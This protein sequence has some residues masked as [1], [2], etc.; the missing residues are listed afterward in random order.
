M[1][2]NEIKTKDDIRQWLKEQERVDNNNFILNKITK[3][4][5]KSN[6]FFLMLDEALLST[7][8]T[9][10]DF[11]IIDEPPIRTRIFNR[12]LPAMEETYIDEL[13]TL[14]RLRRS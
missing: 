6:D 10:R 9:P 5:L 7:R 8:L 4:T 14:L 1:K 11:L 3:S 2:L 12:Y 13:R